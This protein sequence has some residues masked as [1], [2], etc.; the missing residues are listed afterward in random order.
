MKEIK[1]RAWHIKKKGWKGLWIFRGGHTGEY[2]VSNDKIDVLDLTD[3]WD[4]CVLMQYLG[5]LD[6]NGKE[7][8]EG[9]VCLTRMFIVKEGKQ[10]RPEHWF[11]VEPTIES[12]YKVL[13]LNST[14]NIEVVGNIYENA[15]LLNP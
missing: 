4:G 13:C 12:W 14:N 10:T 9:D 7:I 15:E 6:K 8:Y 3:K 11:E 1:F 2:D 5:L